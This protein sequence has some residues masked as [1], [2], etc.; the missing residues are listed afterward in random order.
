MFRALSLASAT[1]AFLA[2][3]IGSWVRI[4]GAGL[5][6]PD[7]PLCRGAVIPVLSGGVVLEWTHRLIAL[8]LSVLV[9]ATLIAAWRERNRIAFVRTI[10][11]LTTAI[12]FVQV[13]LGAL[14]VRLANNPPSVAIHWATGMA[15]LAFLVVLAIL[16]I[17]EP[18]IGIAR[19]QKAD[20]L[21]WTLGALVLFGYCTMDA[22]SMLA[23]LHGPLAMTIHRAIAG[24][25]FILGTL[26]TAWASI[27]APARTRNIVFGAFALLIVQI[28]LGLANV[29][30]GLPTLLREAHAINATAFFV[31]SVCA[32]ASRVLDVAPVRAKVAAVRA[33]LET[34]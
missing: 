23:T 4:N 12:F 29:A 7:W 19:T 31:V 6:C 15:L 33:P 21:T 18:Q 3:V 2:A 14:T 5:T 32:V 13:I 10:A 17:V 26:V 28:M 1:A 8:I 16:S 34:A 11:T 9:V 25:T 20:G 27:A 24:T 22:G 30:F